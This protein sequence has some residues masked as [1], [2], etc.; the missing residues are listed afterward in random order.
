VGDGEYFQEKFNILAGW[1]WHLDLDLPNNG[2][3]GLDPTKPQQRN[4]D[5]LE[6]S[7]VKDGKNF[8]LLL[9]ISRC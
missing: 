5:L 3:L 7:L 9:S 4:N 1:V 2:W 8:I 6:F